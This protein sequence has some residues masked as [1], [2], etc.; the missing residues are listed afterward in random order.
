V[1]KY[2]VIWRILHVLKGRNEDVAKADDLLSMSN[3]EKEYIV[4]LPCYIFVLEM[5]QELELTVSPLC[6][7]GSAEG[8]HDLLNSYSLASELVLCRA[9]PMSQYA[10]NSPWEH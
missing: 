6:Q 5:L 4:E 7:D 10:V 2:S 3:S 9:T 1:K 8:L